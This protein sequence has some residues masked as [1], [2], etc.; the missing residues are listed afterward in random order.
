MP[1]VPSSLSAVCAEVTEFVRVGIGAA[2]NNIAVY[3][4][5]PAVVAKD[6]TEHR[7]SLFF[8][9]FAPFGFD[10]TSHPGDPWRLRMFCLI[11]AFGIDDDTISAGEHDLRILGEVM[12]V[13]REKPVLDPVDVN[14]EKIRLQVVFSPLSDDQIN[15]IWATQGDTAYRPSVLYEMA[16]APILP[17]ERR[18]D[19][20]LVGAVGGEVHPEMNARFAASTNGARSPVVP[21]TTINIENPQWA[22]A[23]CWVDDTACAHTLAFE[24]DSA[25]F[26]AFTPRIWLAGDPGGPVDLVWEKWTAGGWQ[27]AGPAVAATPFGTTIDPENIPPPATVNFPQAVTLP[28][29]LGD[30]PGAGQALLYAT[31]TVVTPSGKTLPKIRSNPL[32]ISLYRSI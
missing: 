15:Q 9:R 7:L 10:S 16:L 24:K 27:E 19:P 1:P 14:G 2:A 17:S 21:K 4:G 30:G 3:M 22:P 31:R 12:R 26:L 32:L 5:A 20:L 25:E 11:T 18:P 23:I 8:Y 29:N 28:E 13:F 6:D